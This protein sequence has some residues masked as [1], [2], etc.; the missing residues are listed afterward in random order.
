MAQK[1]TVAKRDIHSLP[2]GYKD[3]VSQLKNKIKN[4]QI[5]AM[6]SVNRE[7]IRLY[8]DIGKDITKEQEKSGWGSRTIE[9][10]AADLQNAFPGIGGFSPRNVWKMRAFY[11]AY[12]SL[13]DFLPQAVA[14]SPED[15]LLAI[16]ESIPWGHNILLLEK[17]K[18]IKERL[19]YAKMIVSE[20]WSRNGLLD[21]IKTNWYKR[22]GKA[23]TNFDQR[24]PSTQSKLAQETLKDPYNFDFLE[25]REDHIE[26]DIEH[27]LLNHVE[28]FMREMG[29]RFSL[30][31][32]Q[33]QL[34]V[35]DKDFY[36]DL[37]F[38]HL[39]LRCFVV[40][41]LKA[42]EFKPEFA[43]KMNFYLSAISC[44][45]HQTTRPLAS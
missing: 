38:Y 15:D 20:G 4:S 16:L 22:Y 44:V 40:L 25:L 17:L 21:A 7:L 36:L 3:F 32:R 6:S 29:K 43:G 28:K 27:G 30:V 11:T 33:V 5:K 9:K 24:L 45:T 37:L 31:G 1:K 26:R 34:Q 14:E 2:E 23:I 41:E 35:S 39:K 10:V 12:K 18:S 19:W 13:Q 8:W 42:T